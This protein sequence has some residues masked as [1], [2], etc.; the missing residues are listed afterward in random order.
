MLELGFTNF[1]GAAHAALAFLHRRLGLRLWMVTRVQG[2]DWVVLQAEDHG[3][4]VKDGTVFRWADSFCSRM[5]RGEG[6]RIAPRSEEVP[7]YASAPIGRQ[8]RIG[9]YVGVPLIGVD[10]DLFGTLCAIDPEPQSEALEKELEL[11]EMVGALL[12]SLLRTEMQFAEA[13]RQAERVQA[14]ALCDPLTGL[15]NRRGWSQLM[16]REEERCRRHGNQAGVLVLDLDDLKVVNDSLGHPA[17][18]QLISRTSAVL[19]RVLRSQDLAARVGG[20]EFAILAVECG[21][22]AAESLRTRVRAALERDGINAS[23]G[24]AMRHPSRGLQVA[25][26]EADSAMYAEKKQKLAD[27]LPPVKTGA[28]ARLSASG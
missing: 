22:S 15:F 10:G 4:D 11:V 24:L 27:R 13:I 18:D 20:D 17:G 7:A 1:E 26:D 28:V 16:A 2:D 12:G 21:A 14:E 9:A 25:W 8:V 5:V 6:P 23:I 3:Y 19:K